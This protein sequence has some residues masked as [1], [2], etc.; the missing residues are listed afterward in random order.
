M[1]ADL[2]TAAGTYGNWFMAPYDLPSN[3]VL[4]RWNHRTGGLATIEPIQQAGVGMDPW[5]FYQFVRDFYPATGLVRIVLEAGTFPQDK[6]QANLLMG[7]NCRFYGDLMVNEPNCS[8]FFNGLPTPDPG[9]WTGP[10]CRYHNDRIREYFYPNLG[11][12]T[13]WPERTFNSTMAPFGVMQ[14]GLQEM[15]TNASSCPWLPWSPAN[16]DGNNRNPNDTPSPGGLSPGMAAV[17]ALLSLVAAVLM[18]ATVTL[19]FQLRFVQ[20]KHSPLQRSM[21]TQEERL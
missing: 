16:N 13:D 5:P 6:Y 20:N 14:F 15:V 4:M 11:N 21:L 12:Y 2:H 9:K 19:Y 7:V 3:D 10:C 18:A 1:L 8:D 17:V